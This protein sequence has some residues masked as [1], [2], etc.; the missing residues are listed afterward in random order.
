MSI[1]AQLLAGGLDTE[2][3]SNNPEVTFFK[4]VYRRFPFY[5]T[6]RIKVPINSNKDFF[7]LSQSYN[8]PKGK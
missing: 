5:S 7:S 6:E 4:D 2:P 3:F 1:A 8:L